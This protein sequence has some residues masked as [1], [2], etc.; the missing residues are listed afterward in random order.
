MELYDK[1]TVCIDGL[2]A[3]LSVEEGKGI[4][5]YQL[6]EFC[7]GYHKLIHIL[8]VLPKRYKIKWYYSHVKDEEMEAQRH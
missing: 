5:K 8:V 3:N 2:M 7:V 4:S 6:L 1:T